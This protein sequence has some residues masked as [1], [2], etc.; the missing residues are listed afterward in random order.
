MFPLGPAFVS[1]AR[2][3]IKYRATDAISTQRGDECLRC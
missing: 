3:A 2:Q 1:L